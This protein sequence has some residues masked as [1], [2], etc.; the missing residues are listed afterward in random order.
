MSQVSAYFDVKSGCGRPT[1]RTTKNFSSLFPYLDLFNV[2]KVKLDQQKSKLEKKVE[3]GEGG[4]LLNIS[5]GLV[6]LKFAQ[7]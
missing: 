2:L 4:Y 1:G 3:M 7:V 6:V 5:V